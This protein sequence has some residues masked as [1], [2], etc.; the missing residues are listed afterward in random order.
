MR[1]YLLT[2]VLLTT[3][4]YAEA[5]C[6]PPWPQDRECF[7]QQTIYFS[8]AS[9]FLRSETRKEITEVASFLRDHPQWAVLIEG[10]CDDRGSG[11]HNRWLGERRALAVRSELIRAGVSPERIDTIS[12][13]K[14]RPAAVGHDA[15][16]RQRNRRVE[17]TLLTPPR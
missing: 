2:L 4:V 15:K 3:A 5:N 7:R 10:H 6:R 9:P 14:E 13:G 11:G 17:F 12:F 16:A 8:T 1:E